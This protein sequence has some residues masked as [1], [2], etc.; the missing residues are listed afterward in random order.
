VRI[1]TTNPRYAKSITAKSPEEQ[2]LEMVKAGYSTLSP[3][4]YMRLVKGNLDRV[5]DMYQVGRIAK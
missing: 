1:I 3:N 4:E 2:I 5:R